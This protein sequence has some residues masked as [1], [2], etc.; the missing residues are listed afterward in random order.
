MTLSIK[1][2]DMF[3]YKTNEGYFNYSN[4]WGQPFIFYMCN[5]SKNVN[6]R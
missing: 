1:S 4:I 6:R 5:G 3:E 2:N